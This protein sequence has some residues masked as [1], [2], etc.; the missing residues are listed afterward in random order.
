MTASETRQYRWATWLGVI[1]IVFS[2]GAFAWPTWL[3][4]WLGEGAD[5]GD[6][7]IE[8]AVALAFAVVAAGLIVWPYLA[9]RRAVR[10]AR[11]GVRD[12][13]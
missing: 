7:S 8:Y 3:E 12:G 6:G 1:A 9:R 10:V 2:A 13:R 11:L 5:G 4:P